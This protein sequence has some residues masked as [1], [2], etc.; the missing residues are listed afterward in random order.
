MGYDVPYESHIAIPLFLLLIILVGILLD[1]IVIR[2]LLKAVAKTETPLDDIVLKQIRRWLPFWL[3]LLG[4]TVAVESLSIPSKLTAGIH[5][6]VMFAFIGSIVIPA[7]AFVLALLDLWGRRQ[8]SVRT[9]VPTLRWIAKLIFAIIGVLIVLDTLNISITPLLTTLGIGSVAIAL[10]LQDT[11]TNIFAGFYIVADRPFHVGDYVKLDT[12]DEGTVIG[13]GWRSTKIRTLPNTVIVV[14]NQKVA[15]SVVTNY[16]KPE[17]EMAALVQVGVS[18]NSDLKKVEQVTI[19]VAKQV[20]RDVPGGVSTFE[21]FIRYHT[22]GDS[23]I[24]FTVILRVQKFVDRYLI[25]HEFIK[26]LH[27]RYAQEGI[28]IPFPQRV[29]HIQQGKV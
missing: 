20:L 10:A 28:E 9:L 16:D 23:S 27:S 7:T 22:F 3:F 24:N 14:P 21:P 25:T 6:A 29:V 5:I 8:E 19:E 17:Q 12:G 18:Y 15:Q 11:L 13:I 4:V 1:R 26:R 2:I